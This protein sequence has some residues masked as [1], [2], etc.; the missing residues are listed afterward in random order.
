MSI[1]GVATWRAQRCGFKDKIRNGSHLCKIVSIRSKH[2]VQ[3]RKT[4]PISRAW[5][6]KQFALVPVGWSSWRYGVVRDARIVQAWTEED[7]GICCPINNGSPM[8]Y[9][10][11]RELQLQRT[12]APSYSIIMFCGSLNWWRSVLTH[13]TTS[14]PKNYSMPNLTQEE[15]IV[16]DLATAVRPVHGRTWSVE[17]R[18]KS[19]K[20]WPTNWHPVFLD[21]QHYLT[22]LHQDSA[23]WYLRAEVRDKFWIVRGRSFVRMVIRKC[24]TC[25]RYDGRPH[26][27]PA[28]ELHTTVHQESP[29]PEGIQSMDMPVYLLRRTS[30]S[31]RRLDSSILLQT[32]YSEKRISAYA[33]TRPLPRCC[34]I[35][36]STQS[37]KC[38]GL[39]I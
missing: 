1:T 24:V 8:Q 37:L 26:N 25:R 31:L 9:Y 38:N 27:P 16:Q 11:M 2:I 33:F 29:G 36:S 18:R 15:P 14:L 4:L 22:T 28:A 21:S 3:A 20:C 19:W 34:V 7:Q 10:Q 13:P 39:S 32:L 35:F 30:N 12:I 5:T 6:Q 23:Q 17:M